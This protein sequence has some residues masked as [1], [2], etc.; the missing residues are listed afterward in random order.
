MILTSQKCLMLL[1]G[2]LCVGILYLR[3]GDASVCAML[4][5]ITPEHEMNVD[6]QGRLE[7]CSDEKLVKQ[8]ACYSPECPHQ[9]ILRIR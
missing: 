4:K 5:M 9:P 1:S 2:Y 6:T 3:P 7:V 8:V